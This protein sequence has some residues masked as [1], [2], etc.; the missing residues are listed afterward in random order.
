M[1]NLHTQLVR[2]LNKERIKDKHD[3]AFLYAIAEHGTTQPLTPLQEQTVRQVLDHHGIK[4]KDV[5]T[6]DSSDTSVALMDRPSGVKLTYI[7]SEGR[8]GLDT[9]FRY[10]DVCKAMPGRKWDPTR[11][12]WTV[13]ASPT[14][15]KLAIEAF[16]RPEVDDAVQALADTLKKQAD[17]RPT[18][19]AAGLA[20]V[21]NTK[22][23]PWAWQLAAWHF[24]RQRDA[25]MMAM[26]MGTGKTK[27][28]IDLLLNHEGNQLHLVVCPKSV[29]NVWPR[30]FTKFADNHFHVLVLQTK[31]SVA[32]RTENAEQHAACKCGRPHVLL[33]N[34]EAVWREPFA[35]W[36]FKQDWGYVICD[37][38]QR[39]KSPKGRASRH[40]WH[41]GKNAEKRICLSGTPMAQSPLDVWAQYRFLDS[42]IFG[43]SFYS[44]KTRYALMGGFQGK[45]I[46]GLNPTMEQELADLYFQIA[47]EV[48]DTVLTDV[49]ESMDADR[50]VFLSP[51][52]RRTYD[53]LD[54]D[55][56]AEIGGSRH[57]GDAPEITVQNVITKILR[58][59]QLTGGWLKDDE[60]VDHRVCTAKG[61]LLL[62]ILTD[63]NT[64]TQPVVVFC[65][66]RNDL[67]VV[68]E[69]ATKLGLR[70]S[71]ISGR[72]RD[73]LDERAEMNPDT[74]IVGVQMQAGGAGID[75]T[76]AKIGI[77]YSVGHSLS[78]Y[79]QSRARLVRPGQTGKVLL[80]HLVAADTIDVDV[81][82]SLVN[83]HDVIERVLMKGRP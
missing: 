78:D 82:E 24:C 30:E 62:D 41:I 4:L 15:A 57:D 52:A 71:E 40:M 53:S 28:S 42:T 80:L 60:G 47:F 68:E 55:F 59:Q 63:I 1:G 13:P 23:Q 50:H 75:L 35:K 18:L 31:H 69:T 16:P 54:K 14:A 65:K 66:F 9:P 34:Y 45:Q 33:I 10:K 58:L 83:N 81:Y 74:D 29:L 38:S 73:G 6:V 32:R 8:I 19:D 79:K 27:V 46:V 51:K 43:T 76:R 26:D 67:D 5:E 61:D 3:Q 39:I 44:F 56:W 17:N 72:R 36:S 12:I 37:E 64:A 22:I 21:P 2:T 49:P 70:Y 25:A 11:T 20:P 77:Y 48:P 7:A